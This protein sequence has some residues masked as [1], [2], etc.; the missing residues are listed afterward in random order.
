MSLQLGA[1]FLFAQGLVLDLGSFGLRLRDGT[2]CKTE[3]DFLAPF[4]VCDVG[5]WDALHSEDFHLVAVTTR[6]SVVDS[7]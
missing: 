7:G 3:F 2:C 4:V 6:Q 1:Q 5:R